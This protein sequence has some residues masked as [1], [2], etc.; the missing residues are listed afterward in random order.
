MEQTESSL[1]E[2]VT[3]CHD[4]QVVELYQV[5]NPVLLNALAVKKHHCATTPSII[6][7]ALDNFDK[8]LTLQENL[9]DFSVYVCCFQT[10]VFQ[11]I[12]TR[13]LG[14]HISTKIA[15]IIQTFY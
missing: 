8:V 10:N 5:P 12:I 11:G 7:I 14:C 13:E 1:C 3:P 2:S 6:S 15:N 4:A 9:V